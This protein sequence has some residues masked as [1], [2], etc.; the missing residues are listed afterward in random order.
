MRGD[1]L[2]IRHTR[3]MCREGTTLK[4]GRKNGLVRL[5]L[6]VVRQE[7]F[8]AVGLRVDVY[9]QDTLALTGEA[10]GK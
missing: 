4:D 10:G 9:K 2:K 1:D 3:L 6:G 5:Y 7:N 8:A